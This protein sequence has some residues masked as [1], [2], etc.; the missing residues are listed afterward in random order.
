MARI[1]IVVSVIPPIGSPQIHGS[2]PTKPGK[3]LSF[4]EDV[5]LKQYNR[6]SRDTACPR[7]TRT[8][9][10]ASIQEP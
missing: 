3:Y 8:G 10:Q 9:M 7:R 4:T 5:V 1:K 6:K 2:F